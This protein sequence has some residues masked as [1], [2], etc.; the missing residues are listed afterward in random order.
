MMVK[1]LCLLLRQR[2]IDIAFQR[3]DVGLIDVDELYAYVEYILGKAFRMYDPG[4]GIQGHQGLIRWLQ[5]ELDLDH[6]ASDLSGSALV[7]RQDLMD[8]V[9]PAAELETVDRQIDDH[10]G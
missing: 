4:L 8:S 1:C 2:C 7:F 10:G 5:V 9:T 6:D 3:H